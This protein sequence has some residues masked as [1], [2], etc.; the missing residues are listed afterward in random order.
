VAG[1]LTPN[2]CLNISNLAALLTL[3]GTLGV[4]VGVHRLW[5]HRTFTASKPL[6]VFLMFCQTTAG[7]VSKSPK[8]FYSLRL[9]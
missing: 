9:W 8:S 1:F 7:Q 3:L 4:T 5:A 2:I 6:K